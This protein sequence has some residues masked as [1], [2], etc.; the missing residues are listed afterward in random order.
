[1]AKG[2]NELTFEV[3][4]H[5]SVPVYQQI[6]NQIMFGV[7]SRRLKHGDQVPSIKELGDRVGVNFNTIGRI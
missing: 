2:N 7:A 5:S 3:N 4:I 1:M 6:E